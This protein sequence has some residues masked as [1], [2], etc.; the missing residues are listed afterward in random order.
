M[1]ASE[2][3]P[4]PA[5]QP[6][7]NL[8]AEEA[9]VGAV[10]IDSDI[11]FSLSQ[12][13]KVDDFYSVRLGWMWDV[14]SHLSQQQ[15]AIDILTVQ[16]ELERRGQLSEIGGPAYLTRL[17]TRV[18]TA[19]NADSY[20]ALVVETA[21]RRR[22]L[23]AASQIAK[24]AYDQQTDVS[25]ILGQAEQSLFAVRARQ[26]ARDLV[27]V[28]KVASE[29]FDRTQYRY[30]HRDQPLGVPTGF[31]D[32]DQLLGG[33]QRSD[34]VIIAGRPGQGKTGFMVSVAVNAALIYRKQVAL[35]SLEMSNEQMFQRMLAQDTGINT[36]RLRMGNLEPDEWPLF[37]ESIAKLSETGLYL[38]DTPGISP[39]QLLSKCRRLANEVQ[40][41]LIVLD[42]LQLMRSDSQKRDG[43]RVQ[44]V[45][46]ISRGLKLLAR[47][48]NVPV[49]TGAQLSRGVEQRTGQR[50][51]LSDLRESGSI[52]QDADV[53]LFLH[54]PDVWDE[55]P[56]RKN[57]TEIIAAKHRNGPTG[58]VDL[59]FLE[60]LTKF[61]DA[62]QVDVVLDQ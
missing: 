16:L 61:V 7:Y 41:D 34:L 24:L 48:L 51:M 8:E 21:V 55:D 36:H 5:L 26:N 32:L 50:P 47:E 14:Y 23:Q 43:N 20:A 33:L 3:T 18:P 22:L 46:E 31:R 62:A 53:V 11:Y 45:S 17:V 54:H 38:D 27:P 56:T 35:F 37:V 40:L 12:K 15:H 59:V 57:V 6:P 44:E 28:E 29:Y 42:Y 10:L 49:L 30:D 9:V 39:M 25:E 60:S 2:N 1:N 4:S 58:S 13:L 19:Y 52:E